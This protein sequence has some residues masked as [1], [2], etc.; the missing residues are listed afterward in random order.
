MLPC[1]RSCMN[2]VLSRQ[3]ALRVRTIRNYCSR[4]RIL[5]IIQTESIHNTSQ[6][7]PNPPNVGQIRQQ[8]NVY[9]SS[10]LFHYFLQARVDRCR[11]RTEDSIQFRHSAGPLAELTCCFQQ[12]QEQKVSAR[13]HIRPRCDKVGDFTF[14]RREIVGT[15]FQGDRQHGQP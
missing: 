3:R 11:P 14:R 4:H 8:D 9:S 7:S 15:S 13:S 2:P 10:P 5:L 1:G 12:I 6:R